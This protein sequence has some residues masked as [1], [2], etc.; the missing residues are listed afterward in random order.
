MALPFLKRTL[1][2]A[3][4]LLT[5]CL[6]AGWFLIS[7]MARI[8]PADLFCHMPKCRISCSCC[9]SGR[10]SRQT[11]GNSPM[12]LPCTVCVTHQLQAMLGT[13]AV[14]GKQAQ[15]ADPSIMHAL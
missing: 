15:S 1:V 2:P 10:N 9:C 5:A 12:P 7:R 8:S 11:A 4:A 14:P 13:A 3:G 6:K